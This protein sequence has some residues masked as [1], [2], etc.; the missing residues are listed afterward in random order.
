[1]DQMQMAEHQYNQVFVQSG[2]NTVWLKYIQNP[3]FYQRVK[4][5]PKQIKKDVFVNGMSM[6]GGFRLVPVYE[7]ATYSLFED[8]RIVTL[9]GVIIGDASSGNSTPIT[10]NLRQHLGS[11]F[12]NSRTPQTSTLM[13]LVSPVNSMNN[14]PLGHNPQRPFP[15]NSMLNNLSQLSSLGEMKGFSGSSNSS[16]DNTP[17]TDLSSSGG[18]NNSSMQL[19]TPPTPGPHMNN[20]MPNMFMNKNSQPQMFPTATGMNSMRGL[21]NQSNMMYSPSFITGQQ[22]PGG[23]P[24]ILPA[25]FMG[26]NGQTTPPTSMQSSTPPVYGN[27]GNTGFMD[28]KNMMFGQ[29][30]TPSVMAN[31]MQMNGN[32]SPMQIGQPTINMLGGQNRLMNN[33][34]AN[35]TGTSCHQCKN[36]KPFASLSYCQNLFDKTATCGK[37]LCKKKYCDACISKF[38]STTEGKRIPPNSRNN[39]LFTQDDA[40]RDKSW[41]CPSC[42]EFCSCAA[43][44]R[45]KH[46]KANRAAAMKAKS[47]K[48]R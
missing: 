46:K 27:G 1:M 9:T 25:S 3:P 33:R 23:F 37:R 47:N 4:F 19:S 26:F 30:S 39:A 6:G 8:E 45:K 20:G 7:T 5:E 40:N 34:R 22:S 42:Q 12:P 32:L 48:V 21:T 16:G 36:T 41:I 31:S 29:Q 17:M 44:A 2:I 11:A 13:S 18:N 15:K 24:S 10:G 28:K 14:T 35:H 38:Y 43:C